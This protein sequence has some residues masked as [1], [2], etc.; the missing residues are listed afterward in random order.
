MTICVW[1]VYTAKVMQPSKRKRNGFTLIEMLLVIGIIAILAAIV[2]NAIN[3]A[4]QLSDARSVDRAR[5]TREIENAILQYIIDGNEVTVPDGMLNAVPICQDEVDPTD[6]ATV[7]PTGMD[8]SFLVPEYLVSLP[9]DPNETGTKLTG[10]YV[11]RLGAF[12]K[13]CSPVLI[14]E[15]GSAS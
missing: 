7:P 5:A 10:Y 4:K 14:E 8:M 11:F 9:L 13:V 3:P 2:I 12:I 1:S 15:C 6:C